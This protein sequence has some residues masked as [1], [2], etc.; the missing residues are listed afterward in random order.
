MSLVRVLDHRVK[1]SKLK[2]P[3]MQPQKK[4]KSSKR[5]MTP[6]KMMKISILTYLISLRFKKGI[7]LRSRSGR[8]RSSMSSLTS[9]KPLT[10]LTSLLPA[11]HRIA[12]RTHRRS[13]RRMQRI[14]R[15]R[16]TIIM[17]KKMMKHRSS[18]QKSVSQQPIHSNRK[19]C[20]KET[21]MQR[22]LKR[23]RMVNRALHFLLRLI[24]IRA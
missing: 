10:S 3:I 6:R 19:Q 15:M 16:A 14:N 5:T 4:S 11:R 1:H 12:K 22:Q 21:K 9:R 24:R 13:Q 18:S 8:T 17:R 20:P 7:R 23:V 2:N